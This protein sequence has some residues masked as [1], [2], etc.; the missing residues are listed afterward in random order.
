MTLEALRERIGDPQFFAIL[1]RWYA[2]NRYGNVTT[3]QFVA[4]AEQVS[5]Q[6][7]GDFL[8]TWLYQPGKPAYLVDNPKATTPLSIPHR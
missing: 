4:L 8:D 7:L 5:G 6:D 2:Q 1:R 3:A